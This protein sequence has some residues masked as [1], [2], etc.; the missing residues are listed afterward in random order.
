MFNMNKLFF[1]SPWRNLNCTISIAFHSQLK[2]IK[3]LKNVSFLSL[4]PEITIDDKDDTINQ[5]FSEFWRKSNKQWKQYLD[6]ANWEFKGMLLQV[7][8]AAQD[9]WLQMQG[10]RV[11]LQ[12]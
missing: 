3:Y 10:I 9:F 1:M 5:G 6:S 12:S 2:T 7:S 8:N 4:F 11:Q